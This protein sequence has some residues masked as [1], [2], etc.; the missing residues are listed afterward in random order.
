MMC[1]GCVFCVNFRVHMSIPPAVVCARCPVFA[2]LKTEQKFLTLLV[3][4]CIDAT[5]VHVV[6]SMNMSQLL[7]IN[8]IGVSETYY[9]TGG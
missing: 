4:P 8:P 9:E 3:M 6:C 5:A 1:S 7:A 2:S